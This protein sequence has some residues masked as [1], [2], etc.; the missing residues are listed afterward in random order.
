MFDK[1]EHFSQQLYLDSIRGT[2]SLPAFY[3]FKIAVIPE[4]QIKRYSGRMN[5]RWQRAGGK[6]KTNE[7]P[8]NRAL[9]DT[10]DPR[11]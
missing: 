5:A 2:I 7:C 4:E 11:P 1:I 9:S 6:G 3:A 8:H 10:G